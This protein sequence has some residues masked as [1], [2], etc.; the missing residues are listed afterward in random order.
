MSS[1]MFDNLTKAQVEALLECF[2]FISNGY[3]ERA[4][5]EVG[6][7]WVI[8]LQ[9]TRNFKVLRVFIRTDRYKICERG[10]VRKQVLFGATNERFRLVVNSPKSIG[11]VRLNRGV[12]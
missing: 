8:Q 6:N 1:D 4:C 7:L 2:D 5:F 11:V 10:K 3:E 12:S 9:H